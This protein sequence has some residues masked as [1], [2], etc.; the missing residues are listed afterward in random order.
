MDAQEAVN[1]G[2]VAAWEIA[3]HFGVPEELVKL[4]VP[5]ARP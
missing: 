4:Q 3:E 5:L 2:L 1:E